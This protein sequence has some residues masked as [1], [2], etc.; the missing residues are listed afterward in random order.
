MIRQTKVILLAGV[1]VFAIG[2][3]GINV[4]LLIVRL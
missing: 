2:W 4:S 3:P 1:A